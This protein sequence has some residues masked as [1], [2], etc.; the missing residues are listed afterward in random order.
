MPEKIAAAVLAVMG[1]VGY[2]QKKG[3]NADHKYK[4]AAIGDVLAKVQPAMVEAGLLILQNQEKIEFWFESRLLVV[5]YAFSLQHESGALWDAHITHTGIALIQFKS[6]GLDDKALNKCHT[7][8]RKYFQLG[9]F[10]IPTGDLPDPDEDNDGQR[11]KDPNVTRV[12]VNPDGTVSNPPAEMSASD[13]HAYGSPAEIVS[14]T[15]MQTMA[16][17]WTKAAIDEIAE[18]DEVSLD[19]WLLE[20]DETILKLHRVDEKLH[21]KLIIA[22]RDRQAK[23][24]G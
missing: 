22:V 10:Q 23:I 20:N 9:L 14:R 2:V 3:F 7:A 17:D 11:N 1:K 4:F 16:E 12:L 24:V 18:M 21:A 8:A 13:L 15:R 19:R 6:G 5:T